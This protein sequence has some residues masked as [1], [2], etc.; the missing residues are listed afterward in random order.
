M[1]KDP[2]PPDYYFGLVEKIVE[3]L[4]KKLHISLKI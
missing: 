4:R 1:F 2:E 3:E